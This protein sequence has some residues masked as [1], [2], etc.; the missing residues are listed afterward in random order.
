M[1][2]DRLRGKSGRRVQVWS[3][4]EG[5]RII[6]RPSYFRHALT[7][8]HR[9][10]QMFGLLGQALLAALTGGGAGEVAGGA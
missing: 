1:L 7:C 9:G 4:S 8:P 6:V 3:D 5:C 10:P 2:G